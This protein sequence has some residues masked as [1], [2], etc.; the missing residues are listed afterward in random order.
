MVETHKIATGGAGPNNAAGDGVSGAPSGG[1]THGRVG[2][3]ESS[4]G[5]YPNP[6]TGKEPADHGFMG[7]GGQT[8]I[9]Y[10]GGNN[11]NSP[12]GMTD[13]EG[14]ARAAAAPSAER[15]PHA[16]AANGRAFDIVEDSGV[17][18][19]EAEI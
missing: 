3:G 14:G 13:E 9:D 8:E 15:K 18:A 16:V 12:S 5:A 7:H 1:E 2:G 4:G 10:Y 19:A 11:P 17:A 6:H